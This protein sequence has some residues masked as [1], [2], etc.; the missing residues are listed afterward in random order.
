MLTH[1]NPKLPIREKEILK[2]FYIRQLG[3][4][5]MGSENYAQYLTEE[6]NQVEIYF[7]NLKGLNQKKVTAAEKSDYNK[8]PHYH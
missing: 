1:I 8:K 5:D 4:I 6:N 7:L 3:F 2:I